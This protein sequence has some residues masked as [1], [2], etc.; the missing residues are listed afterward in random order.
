MVDLIYSLSTYEFKD[1][2]EGI[3]RPCCKGKKKELKKRVDIYAKVGIM[4][5]ISPGKRE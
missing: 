3:E 5:R 2:L 1:Q 4:N